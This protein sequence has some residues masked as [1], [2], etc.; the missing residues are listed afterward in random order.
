VQHPGGQEVCGTKQP[1]FIGI[2]V[3]GLQLDPDILRLQ[4]YSSARDR[5][6]SHAAVAQASTH[7]DAFRVPPRPDTQEPLDDTRELMG[8][9]L[10]RA[11]YNRS[12]FRIAFGEEMTLGS[13]EAPW[14]G[15]VGCC[16]CRSRPGLLIWKLS[17]RK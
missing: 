1:R 13:V 15:R 3:N 16:D 4:K 6:L 14:V 9:L 5:Q 2:V 7:D 17:A 8:K 10:D 11:L 12:R